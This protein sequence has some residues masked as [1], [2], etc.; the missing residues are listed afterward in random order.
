MDMI[1][2][3]SQTQTGLTITLLSSRLQFKS[4]PT[5][6]L[7]FLFFLVLSCR[8]VSALAEPTISNP[9]LNQSAQAIADAYGDQTKY[10]ISRNGKTIGEHVLTFEQIGDELIVKVD[11]KITVRILKIPV[12]RLSYKAE[13]RWVDG[14]LLTA[15]A[16]TVENGESTTV[17]LD[18]S[19]AVDEKDHIA[20]ASNHWHPGVLTGASV[21]NTLTGEE[22]RITVT[23][24]GTEELETASG[25]ITAEHYQYDDDIQA[26]VWYDT[27]GLWLL[28]KF[29]GQ[30]G[31]VIQ[32]TRQD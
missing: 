24:L 19:T 4:V 31:S 29:K 9:L 28:M 13:E 23:H 1:R 27:D 22:S 2:H 5:T 26:N 11:S 7:V 10:R 3:A 6:V 32:Y 17:S 21:F 12:Y 16:T 8:P 18:N 30:D 20:F 15:A 25:T 14:S